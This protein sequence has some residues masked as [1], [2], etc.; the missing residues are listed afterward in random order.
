MKNK[1]IL[2]SFLILGISGKTLCQQVYVDGNTGSCVAETDNMYFDF[3]SETRDTRIRCEL[4]INNAG[5]FAFV[6]WF[7]EYKTIVDS[8]NIYWTPI[9]KN[10]FSVP[11]SFD[12][13]KKQ[14]FLKVIN[15]STSQLKNVNYRN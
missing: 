8:S 2:I 4:S 6:K 12:S 1:I 7:Y 11:I 9:A 13:L 10:N 3:L 14:L 5:T 15:D